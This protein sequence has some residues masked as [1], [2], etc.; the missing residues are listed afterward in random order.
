MDARIPLLLQGKLDRRQLLRST[1][2][3][4]GLGAFAALSGA[5]GTA[6][7]DPKPPHSW[8]IMAYTG[9]YPAGPNGIGRP[10][11]D[12]S[13]VPVSQNA[14]FTFVL[15]F[16]RDIKRDGIFQP[17]WDSAITPQGIA[18][19]KAAG[20]RSFFASLGGGDNFPWQAPT[21]E[22]AW[23]ANAVSSLMNLRSTYHL[24]GFD[25]NY[26]QGLDDSFPRVMSQV[27]NALNDSPNWPPRFQTAFTLTPFGQTWPYYRTLY[28]LSGTWIQQINYQAYADGLD[29]PGYLNLYSSLTQADY[30]WGYTK[31][32]LGIASST[33]EPRGLQ[34]PDIFGVWDSLYGNGSQCAMIWCLEDSAEN[35]YYIERS[36]QMRTPTGP[37]VSV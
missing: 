19:L 33:A 30:G 35:D 8:R 17:V 24:D 26:E 11:P 13:T 34:P 25:V 4:G 27:I 36:L 10:A 20:G 9:A 6:A 5:V 15:A 12:L 29:A 14:N 22:S 7:A 23:I 1:A 32:G 18:Q 21:D 3:A 2:I 28:P 31:M 16:A 37:P